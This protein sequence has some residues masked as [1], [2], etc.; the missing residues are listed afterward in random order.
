MNSKNDRAYNKIV[1]AWCMYDWANSAFA[2]TIMAAM[3]PP[4][5]RSLVTESGLRRINGHRVLGLHRLRRAALDRADRPCSGR[6]LGSYR[7]QE[8]VYCLFC[9][10]WALCP[11]GC[12]S[13]SATTR[14]SW[15]PSSLSAGTWGL[16]GP[17]SFTSR[18]CP[19][20]PREDDID[21][22]STRGYALGYVGGGILLIINVIWFMR[23]DLF[24]MPCAGFAMRAAFFSVAVWWAVFSIPLFRNVPEPPA[25]RTE[26][27]E[28]QSRRGGFW[29]SD[30]HLSQDHSATS[31]C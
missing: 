13:F 18:C 3:F 26:P 11:P 16:R 8:M 30:P 6:H 28:R 2:T 19:I 15:A 5:Y 24:F 4:F 22:I 25:V 9:R 14:I 12:L 29:A 31:S 10:D 27:G 21:Q 20:S 1:N 23:P 17:T 7:R